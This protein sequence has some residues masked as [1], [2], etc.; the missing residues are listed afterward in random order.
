MYGK[1]EHGTF[2]IVACDADRR[3]WGV[4]V[5]TKPT[6]V[7]A[8]VPWAE[9]RVGSIATQASANYYYGPRGLELLRRGLSAEEVVRRLTR[10]DARREHRQLGV[11]DRRGRAAAWT[12][13][14]C[15]EYALHHVGEGYACQGNMLA[16]ATVVPAMAKAFESARG[17]LALR[18]LAALRAGAG[19]GGDKRGME[20]AAMIVVHREP[21]FDA[22]WSDYW[23]NLRVDRS[24]QPIRDLGRLLRKDEAEIQQFLAQRAAAARKRKKARA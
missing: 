13:A 24:P 18:M 15:I 5:S 11:L 20:S 21:G 22:A 1:W 4:A 16:S 3:F 9:W 10:P 2:S 12:G 14:K 7:G 23:V 17:T 8:I 6:S 19:E